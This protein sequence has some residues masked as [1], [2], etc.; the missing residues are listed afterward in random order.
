MNRVRFIFCISLAEVSLSEVSLKLKIHQY[1]DDDDDLAG[2]WEAKPILI[3]CH[4]FRRY[5][6]V[7]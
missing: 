6:I 2:Y 4:W 1:D 7:L 5:N 3:Y